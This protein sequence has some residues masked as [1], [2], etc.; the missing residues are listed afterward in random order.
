MEVSF[1]VK[2]MMSKSVIKERKNI[3]KYLKFYRQNIIKICIM[4]L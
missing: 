1:F 3:K 4:Y 2:E